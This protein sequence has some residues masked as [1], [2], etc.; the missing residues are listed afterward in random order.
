MVTEITLKLAPIPEETGVGV[1]TFP[2]MRAAAKTATDV[3]QKGISIQAVEILDDVQMSVINRVGNTNR[4]WKEL[5]TLFFKFA[6]SKNGVKDSIVEVNNI[7]KANGGSDFEFAQGEEQQKRLWSARKE[8]LWS[9]LSLRT[10]GGEVWSTDVAVPLSR[11]PEL[12][13]MVFES[14][15]IPAGKLY[16]E[17]KM[18]TWCHRGL[19]EGPRRP[20]A[21]WRHARPHRR[22]QL[23]RDDPI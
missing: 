8:A 5:P 23:P 6:G 17:S 16:G 22:W 2:S 13:G 20:R 1:V 10:E 3:I 4:A 19:Q 12:V 11:I 15:R 21:L 14:S 18:L 9:M 7:V